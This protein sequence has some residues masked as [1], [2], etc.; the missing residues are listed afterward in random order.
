MQYILN[1]KGTRLQKYFMMNQNKIYNNNNNNFKNSETGYNFAKQAN[2][3]FILK[4]LS[5]QNISPLA[6]TNN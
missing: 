2:T 4:N 5:Q 6:V 3:F 1:V